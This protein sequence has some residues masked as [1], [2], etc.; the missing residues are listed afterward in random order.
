MEAIEEILKSYKHLRVVRE[1]AINGPSTKYMLQKNTGIG[2]RELGKA[3]EIL[4]RHGWVSRDDYRPH[5]YRLNE[6]REDVGMLL[7]LLRHH[8]YI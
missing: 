1:L 6:G 8:S 5:K 3:L 4:M 2:P 7:E